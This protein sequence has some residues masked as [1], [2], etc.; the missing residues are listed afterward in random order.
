MQ[1]VCKDFVTSNNQFI[2]LSCWNKCNNFE[3]ACILKEKRKNICDS[4]PLS[5][6]VYD[7]IL[8][9]CKLSINIFYM[10]FEKVYISYFLFNF[11]LKS[12][13]FKKIIY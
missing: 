11:Y 10:I 4:L 3:I 13:L 7:I 6:S 1:K 12:F 2:A 5:L 8:I 9:I